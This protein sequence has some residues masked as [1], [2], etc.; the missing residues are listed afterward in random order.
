MN[1]ST[2]IHDTTDG[3]AST[4]AT[5]VKAQHELEPF[6]TVDLLSFWMHQ[7]FNNPRIKISTNERGNLITVTYGGA[8][9]AP[10]A[11]KLLSIHVSA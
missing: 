10:T 1:L 2:T 4:M 9:A 8:T 6:T 11:K 3:F 7:R 5:E